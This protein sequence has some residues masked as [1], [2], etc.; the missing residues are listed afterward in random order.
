MTTYRQVRITTDKFSDRGVRSGTKGFVI[1]TYPDGA[2]EIEIVNPDGSTLAQF[3]AQPDEFESVEG[4][5]N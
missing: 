5:A 3:V 2:S 1:E 4:S